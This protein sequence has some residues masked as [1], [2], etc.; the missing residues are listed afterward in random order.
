MDITQ[1]FERCIVGSSPAGGKI[2]QSRQTALPA[3]NFASRSDIFVLRSKGKNREAGSRNF[4]VRK[5][6][7]D[8]NSKLKDKGQ[9]MD[10]G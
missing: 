7:C 2:A 6:I 8:Q 5:N 1:R 3:S 10:C 4:S 9:L